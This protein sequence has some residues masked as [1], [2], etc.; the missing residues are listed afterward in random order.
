MAGGASG[1]QSHQDAVASALLA[2][3][4]AAQQQQRGR[5]APGPALHEV[6]RG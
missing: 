1:S 3:L 2:G 4:A 6:R 5:H